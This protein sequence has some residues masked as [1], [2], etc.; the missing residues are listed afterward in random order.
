[1]TAL[2]TGIIRTTCTPAGIF[3]LMTVTGTRPLYDPA[4]QNQVLQ[5]HGH[6]PALFDRFKPH[7]V[8][9]HPEGWRTCWYAWRFADKEAI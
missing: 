1:M 9:P 2:P 6:D 3:L 5:R 8:T 4:E 7:L